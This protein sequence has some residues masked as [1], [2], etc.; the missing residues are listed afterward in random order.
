MSDEDILVSKNIYGNYWTSID[1]DKIVWLS[2]YD[3]Y[4]E[5]PVYADANYRIIV[6]NITSGEETQIP[7]NS[8]RP[9]SPGISGKYVVW[10]GSRFGSSTG[11]DIYLHDLESGITKAVTTEYGDQKN[12]V[13]AGDIIIWN[14]YFGP[15]KTMARI[16]IY[17]ISDQSLLDFEFKSPKGNI[18]DTDGKNILISVRNETSYSIYLYNL[19]G[20]E[21]SLIYEGRGSAGVSI[22]GDNAGWVE[23]IYRGGDPALYKLIF[24]NISS[25]ET[26]TLNEGLIPIGDLDI[27]ENLA[28]YLYGNYG[29]TYD[30]NGTSVYFYDLRTKEGGLLSERD[31]NQRN[32]SVSDGIIVWQDWYPGNQGLYLRYY[33]KYPDAMD[34]LVNQSEIISAVS[35]ESVETPGF[36]LIAV[37]MGFVLIYLIHGYRKE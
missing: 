24:Y 30:K 32:P 22:S 18:A 1:G 37:F 27:D 19:S 23:H 25:R 28:V 14:E 15:G 35:G 5:H 4:Y 20:G 9:E 33:D 17:N 26:V 7:V 31:G 6:H 10:C 16:S 12:P 36:G 3:R 11:Y 21:K 34:S 13:I 2:K 8:S 29:A